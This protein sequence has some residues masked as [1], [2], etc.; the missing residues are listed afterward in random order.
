MRKLHFIFFLLPLLV[1]CKK[2]G[3]SPETGNLEINCSSLPISN[4]N[5]SIYT[6]DQYYLYISNQF[7]LP[8][9]EGVASKNNT[10]TIKG[11]QRGYY[12]VRVYGEGSAWIKPI[13]I[14]P[15]KVNKISFP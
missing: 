9:F 13:S 6:E 1:G 3:L 2:E 7:S 11:L 10:T 15:N 8:I 5:Y 4:V 12:G 14:I